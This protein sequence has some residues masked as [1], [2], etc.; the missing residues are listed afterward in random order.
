MFSAPFTDGPKHG[1]YDIRFPAAIGANDGRDP[2][3]EGKM[4][5]IYKRFES[6]HL[7][8]FKSHGTLLFKSKSGYQEIRLS[9]NGYQP[10]GHQVQKF[11]IFCLS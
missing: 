5:A 7:K 11:I 10:S 2:F 1:I 6:G 8:R 9:G 3:G 4:K